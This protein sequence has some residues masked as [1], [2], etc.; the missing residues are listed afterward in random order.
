MARDGLC[1]HFARRPST[2]LSPPSHMVEGGSRVS[3]G[4]PKAQSIV[5]G[6]ATAT[7]NIILTLIVFDRVVY[8]L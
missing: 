1:K 8:I 7:V 3:S 6:V 5:F 4:E 2:P